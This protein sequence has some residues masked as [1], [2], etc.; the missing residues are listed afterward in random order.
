MKRLWVGVG[1]GLLG[2]LRVRQ[3]GRQA[4]R[5]REGRHL[6][7]PGPETQQLIQTVQLLTFFL[8][9]GTESIILITKQVKPLPE[10]KEYERTVFINIKHLTEGL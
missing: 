9:Q 4:G 6:P 10:D 3:E 7:A 1:G 2:L 8:L 5:H